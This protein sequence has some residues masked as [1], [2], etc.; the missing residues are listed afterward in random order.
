MSHTVS[1]KEGVRDMRDLDHLR[2]SLDLHNLEVD[3]MIGC[4]AYNNTF[5][6]SAKP[7]GR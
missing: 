4:A 5:A 2:I 6:N 1:E 7:M 3:W